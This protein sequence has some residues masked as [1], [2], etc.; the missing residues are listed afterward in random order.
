MNGMEGTIWTTNEEKG[1]TVCFKDKLIRQ[2]L[3]HLGRDNYNQV[4]VGGTGA[5]LH[6]GKTQRKLE[7]GVKLKYYNHRKTKTQKTRIMTVPPP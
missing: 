5:E 7:T 1:H 2:K 4:R 6:E 3:Q